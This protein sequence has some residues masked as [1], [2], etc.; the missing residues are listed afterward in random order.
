MNA[1]MGFNLVVL[2]TVLCLFVKAVNKLNAPVSC[3]K[4]SRVVI[5]IEV[6]R[7]I[8]LATLGL[9]I[10]GPPLILL[11]PVYLL[12]ELCAAL[13]AERVE[14]EKQRD[15]LSQHP[16]RPRMDRGPAIS[17]DT[18][19]PVGWVACVMLLASIFGMICGVHPPTS[20]AT[21]LTPGK[22]AVYGSTTII[23]RDPNG[24]LIIQDGKTQEILFREL[25]T[26]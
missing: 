12:M 9:L 23:T 21:P 22:G 10:L 24:Y 5:G 19:M 3:H 2:V 25:P 15:A 6:G 14:G 20:T 11:L 13:E 17:S 16:Y 26:L 18:K 7:E 4:K 1:V 8:I